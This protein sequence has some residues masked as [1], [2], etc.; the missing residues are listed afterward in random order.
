MSATLGHMAAALGP[1][2]AALGPKAFGPT[3]ADEALKDSEELSKLFEDQ[4]L[5][6]MELCKT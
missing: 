3:T 5:Q 2:A 6:G 1:M 4:S